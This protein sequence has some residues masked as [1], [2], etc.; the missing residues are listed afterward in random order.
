VKINGRFG[1]ACTTPVAPGLVVENDTEEL[2]EMR[3]DLVD[4]LFVEGNHFCMFCEES[5]ACELQALAYR[6]GITAPRYPY[7]FPRRTVD[8]THPEVLLDRN[9]CVLCARC[10]RASRE[11]DRHHELGFAGR[12]RDKRVAA[13]SRHGLAGTRIAGSASAVEACPTGS[14]VAK[15]E[16][17]RVP[18]GQRP[19]D[20]V[21]IGSEVESS[22]GRSSE[23][24][25][26]R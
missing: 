1:A 12:G 11:V 14:L 16:G 24:S 10:I 26:G 17:F 4:M 8:A 15:R 2:L 6:F 9:R 7:L 5:G 3:R 20:R 22:D 25:G 18:I 23:D 19:Y 13:D 21:P